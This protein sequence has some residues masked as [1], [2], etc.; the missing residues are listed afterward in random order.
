[1]RGV[2]SWQ[3]VA[4]R[5]PT[6]KRAMQ[7]GAAPGAQSSAG[8]TP[9]RRSLH[10]CAETAPLAPDWPQH[11]RRASARGRLPACS[12]GGRRKW[13][14][15]LGS[16][17][18]VWCGTAKHRCRHIQLLR[19]GNSLPPPQGDVQP[20]AAPRQQLGVGAIVRRHQRPPGL[21]RILILVMQRRAAP[22]ASIAGAGAVR[23]RRGAGW[24]EVVGARDGSTPALMR[25][26]LPALQAQAARE[27]SEQ[28]RPAPASRV[29]VPHEEH[30]PPRRRSWR[31]RRLQ[32]GAGGVERNGLQP[33]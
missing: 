25:R 33:G 27:P 15:Q 10:P 20:A 17:L 1:M 16:Q 14:G 12:R 11:G 5:W 6:C 19:S 3:R 31:R 29:A 22:V 13:C 30:A 28:C 2:L 7:A 24:G 18:L 26:G 8:C 23:G 4:G 9:M 32:E 21:E